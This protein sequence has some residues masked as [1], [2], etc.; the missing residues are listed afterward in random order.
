M[1]GRDRRAMGTWWGRGWR[2]ALGAVAIV[3]VLAA[4]GAAPPSPTAA[5]SASEASP[6]PL[7]LPQI[8]AEIERDYAGRFIEIG[9]GA[10]PLI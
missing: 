3:S 8:R 6:T 10:P 4:C 5:P 1:S 7:D 2:G 9:D